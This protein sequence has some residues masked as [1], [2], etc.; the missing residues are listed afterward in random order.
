MAKRTEQVDRS[1]WA[2]ASDDVTFSV[3]SG[4]FSLH[5]GDTSWCVEDQTGKV[6]TRQKI[7]T[8][9]KIGIEE[10]VC[11]SMTESVTVSTG[12]C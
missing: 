6:T 7:S 8:K 2:V 9:R 4:S 11:G 12:R 3:T 1:V 10:G 5:L